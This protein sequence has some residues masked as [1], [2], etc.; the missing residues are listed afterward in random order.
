MD[1]TL[2]TIALPGLVIDTD[3]SPVGVRSEVTNTLAG[4]VVIWEQ[5]SA[6]GRSFNLI[7]GADYGWMQRSALLAL[8]SL[9]SVPGQTY[10]LTFVAADPEA[11]PPVEA[12][13][14]TVRFRN[15]DAP[16]I[17]ARPIV[18]RPFPEASDWYNEITIKLME[19]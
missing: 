6:A 12:V 1:M 4:G 13:T 19:V 2:E 14:M 11:E 10:T 18:A 9:A 7:G 16:A 3:M 15:E 8:R 17:E 5:A